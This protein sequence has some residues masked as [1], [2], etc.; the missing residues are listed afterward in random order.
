MPDIKRKALI[1]FGIVDTAV[2]LIRLLQKMF[3]VQVFFIERYESDKVDAL[4]SFGLKWIKREYSEFSEHINGMFLA[5]EFAEEIYENT[6]QSKM[7]HFINQALDRQ[8]GHQKEMMVIWKYHLFKGISN[9]AEQYAAALYLKRNRKYDSIAIVSFNSLAYFVNAR[10]EGA[11]GIYRLPGLFFCKGIKKAGL[12]TLQILRSTFRILGHQSAIA[13]SPSAENEF[14]SR[15]IDIE[16]VQI[17][18][19]PHQGVYY[20]DMF[21]KDHFY[22]ENQGS[23]LHKSKLLHMSLGE[24]NA[25]HMMRNYTFYSENGIPYMDINDLSCKKIKIAESVFKLC[26]ALNTR[27]FAD[28]VNFGFWYVSYCLYLFASIKKYCLIFS[29]FTSLK[30]ALLGYEHLFPRNIAVALSLLNIK[31][32]A[33]QERL[34]LAFWP[35]NYYILNY[36]YVV[37]RVVMERGLKNSVVGHCIP[38]GMVREDILFSYEQRQIFDEKYD[39]IKR[40]KKLILALDYHMA[41]DGVED[42]LRHTG[43]IWQIKQFYRDLMRLAKDIPGIHIVIK[44]KEAEPYSNPYVKDILHEIDK[45][46]NIEVELDLRRYNPYFLSEKADLTVALHTS[47]CDELLAADRKVIFYEVT[48]HIKTLLLNYDELPI[49]THSYDELKYHVEKA[50]QGTCMEVQARER[51]K[52]YYYQRCYHGNVQQLIRSNIEQIINNLKESAT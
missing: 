3:R 22:A 21:K 46:D 52:E 13:Q 8:N 42:T 9:F 43:K 27:L 6:K 16:D 26:I 19:F 47:L 2:P 29:R 25:P 44:G 11:I 48:D 7:R 41:Q 24:K 20:A 39:N 40:T 49:I 51:L 12:M 33:A 30:V 5:S 37:G 15:P 14:R 18:Y 28:L 4:E 38:V 45:I 31:L 1:F 34:I 17:I 50:L 36:Y 32:V 23:P 10:R 35:D